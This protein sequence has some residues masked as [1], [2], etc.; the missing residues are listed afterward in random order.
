ML[1]RGI[2]KSTSRVDNEEKIAF[3]TPFGIF[4]YT[5]MAFGLKNGGA[6]YKKCV[7]TVLEGQIGQDIEAYID[8]IVVKSEKREDLLDDLKETF[9][10]LRRFKMM[11]NPKKCVF[12]VSSGKL[13]G[14]M[15][16]SR[17]IDAN[18]KKVEA[19]ENLQPPQTRKEIQKLADMMTA[20]SR[21][22]SK[23]GERGMS[24][25]K[26]LCKADGFQWD[27]QA[28]VTFVKLKQYL[29]SLPTLV[30]PKPDD[31]LLLYVAAID[32][33]V[34][35]V[36]VVE[37]LE[38]L[39]E[40]KQ[41][42]VYFVSEILKDPQ[43]RYPQVQKLLYAVLMTIK[44]LKHYFLVHTVWVNRPLARVLQSKEATW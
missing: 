3:I 33:V 9:D 32:A 25:Y 37:R 38:A 4:C 14:Y 35:T 39:T 11:L 41:Q 28:A 21:F 42:P 12:D 16:S 34:S 23:L 26:L 20:L 36:I 22:I 24:F 29:K 8:D 7:H 44:K 5:K 30:P 15:V 18:P 17:G 2:I 31:V 1:I 6:T 40:V 19:I 27:D 43:T 13:L 10:N